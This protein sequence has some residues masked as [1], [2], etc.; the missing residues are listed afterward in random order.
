MK[1]A[2]TSVATTVAADPPAVLLPYQARWIEDRAQV[3]LCEKSRR[4]GFTWGE[5][6]DDVLIAASQKPAGGQN[7]WYIGYNLEMAKE[8]IDA[9]AMWAKAYQ[10][11]AS[12]IEE[13]VLEDEDK[14]IRTYIIRFDSGHRITALSSRPSNLRGKQG[15]VVIDEAAFHESL[16]ELIKAAIALLIWGGKVRIISTHDGDQNSFNELILACRA[17][18]LPYSVHRLDFRTA[19]AEGLYRRVC[20]RLDKQ[21]SPDAEDA[22]VRE[23]YAFYG[24]NAAEELDVIPSS[25]EGAFLSRAL[26]ETCMDELIPVIRWTQ[27]ATFAEQPGHVREAECHDFCQSLMSLIALLPTGQKHYFGSD[28]ARSGDVSVIWPLTETPGLQM[29]T[30]FVIELR[31]IPFEQQRQVLFFLGRRLP[32]F[33]GGAM[34]A[35]G[36]GQYLAEVAMQE[37]GASRIAQVMLSVEWYR[38]NMPPFRAAFEDRT[39]RVP[40][41]A[42]I[43][44]DLRSIKKDRG[45]A[46]VPDNAT[47]RGTDGQQRHGD[48]AVAAAL[49]VYAVRMLDAAPIEFQSTDPRASLRLIDQEAVTRRATDVGFGTIRG[50][51]DFGGY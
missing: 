17:G 42:D 27:P 15:V 21:W 7:V 51:N 41:D 19:V 40:R 25:G 8:Y 16:D 37:F 2:P 33:S 18:K 29:V 23:V 1:R 45:I 49:A 10:R 50:G 34:D 44:S 43:L 5:A 4:T 12:D 48:A 32:R 39:I 24:D 14:Q 9:C 26:I 38:E 3:K 20:L 47:Y 28:F 13:G 31:N 36:N 46:K 22:W 6:A 35:R 30:P 11:A